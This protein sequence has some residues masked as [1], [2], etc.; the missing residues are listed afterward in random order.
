[1]AEENQT[2]DPDASFKAIIEEAQKI[3]E[4]L[5]EKRT[6]AQTEVAELRASIQPQIDKLKPVIQ[7]AHSKIAPLDELATNARRAMRLKG[8]M[9]ANALKSLEKKLEALR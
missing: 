4:P 5:D 3:K 8:D 2:P 1:M 7:E 9:K 6:K